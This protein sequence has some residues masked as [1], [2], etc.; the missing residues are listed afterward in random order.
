MTQVRPR[1]AVLAT[2]AALALAAS[3]YFP[4]LA[5]DSPRQVPLREL[6]LQPE[7]TALLPSYWESMAAPLAVAGAVGTLGALLCWRPLLVLSFLAGLVTVGLWITT[8]L[9]ELEPAEFAIGDVQ[10]GAWISVGAIVLLLLATIALRRRASDEEEAEETE[11][12]DEDEDVPHD[13]PW[14]S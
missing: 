6:F 2:I 12:A 1:A 14:A 13:V 7:S 10:L 3:A 9:A 5:D 8:V 11:Q 4:W